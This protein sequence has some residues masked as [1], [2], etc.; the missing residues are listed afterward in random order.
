MLRAPASRTCAAER[1]HAA[2]IVRSTLSCRTGGASHVP[3]IG[4][5]KSRRRARLKK[6]IPLA[7]APRCKHCSWP[8]STKDARFMSVAMT[9]L[10]PGLRLDTAAAAMPVANSCSTIY[11]AHLRVLNQALVPNAHRHTS[12]LDIPLL[13]LRNMCLDTHI[14]RSEILS[15]IQLCCTVS[16][17]GCCPVTSS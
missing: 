5:C 4:L 2:I 17:L 13:S 12:S 8:T 14:W 6:S 7:R 3:Y 16:A 1:R 11:E 9:S 15:C 10:L